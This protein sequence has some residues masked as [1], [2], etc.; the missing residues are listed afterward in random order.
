L[1]QQETASGNGT[2]GVLLALTGLP[3]N[4]AEPDRPYVIEAASALNQAVLENREKKDL[5]GHTSTVNSAAFSPDGRRI[6]TASGDHTARVWRVFPNTQ[7]LIDY[8]S[9]TVPLQLT[10]EQLHQFFLDDEP[11]EGAEDHLGSWSWWRLLGLR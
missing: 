11:A 8:A 7:S 9:V 10:P 2:N 4:T 1:S 3:K 6:V 5:R